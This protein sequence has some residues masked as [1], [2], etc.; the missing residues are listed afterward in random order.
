[1]GKKRAGIAEALFSR[2]Q[3]AVLGLV[4]SQPERR[5]YLSEIVRQAQKGTGA[6]YRELGRLASAGLVT[7]LNVGGKKLYQAN[8]ASPVFDELVGLIA[9][10]SAEAPAVR[11]PSARYE[12]GAPLAVPRARL[13]SLCRKYHVRRLGL[14]G[15]AARGELAP[16]SDVDLLVEFEP[17]RAPS[18]WAEPE[19]REAFGALF[20]GR[21]VDLVPPDVLQNP[22]RRKAILRDLRVLYEA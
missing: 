19:M 17:G 4:F 9:K 3:E 7:V 5:F 6:V 18:L 22:Y 14:F 10:L 11:A 8:R 1:M 16:E 2:T 13:A 20:G 15:S 12:T 21:H